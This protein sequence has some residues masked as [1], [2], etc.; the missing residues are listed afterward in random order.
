MIIWIM[1][2]LKT[3]FISGSN[4]VVKFVSKSSLLLVMMKILMELQISRIRTVA[5]ANDLVI[6]VPGGYFK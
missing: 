5:C 6:L 3:H 1:A 4:K 2:V